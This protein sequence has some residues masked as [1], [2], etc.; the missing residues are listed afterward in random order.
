MDTLGPIAAGCFVTA[1]AMYPVDVV[2]A[3]RMASADG[4]MDSTVMLV[5]RFV[6]VHGMAGLVRQGVLPEVVRATWMR[7]VQFF[8]MP[9][10][11]QKLFGQPV[12]KGTMLSKSTAGVMAT[13]PAVLSIT[14]LENA[15]IALQLD[16]TKQ[17]GNSMVRVLQQ[18]WG[19]SWAAPLIG[20][21]GVQ[22]RQAAW[23]A[24]YVCSL[25]PLERR[26]KAVCG[27]MPGAD[28]I[29][30]V[31]GGFAAGTL[32]SAI[33]TPFDVVRTNLQKEGIQ[34]SATGMTSSE[35]YSMAFGLSDY[36]R[37]GN[38]IVSQNGILAM[39]RGFA[40]KAVHLGGSGACLAFFIPFFQR[41][42]GVNVGI[43]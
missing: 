27:D 19:R 6:S 24:P 21:Q 26:C 12:G 13:V 33:N 22:M 39:Y 15:K 16:H 23:F 35:V 43:A 41:A 32:G 28:G 34:R 37:L 31:L 10:F 42:M 36:V 4:A 3:L 11:H 38:K 25:G 14:P 30:K 29:S 40:F 9:Y 18:L 2:R 7:C 20:W 8:C 17:Y 1:A 5:R